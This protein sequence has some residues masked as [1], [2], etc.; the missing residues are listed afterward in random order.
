M[1]TKNNIGV[2]DLDNSYFLYEDVDKVLNDIG[3]LYDVNFTMNSI[4]FTSKTID[5][6]HWVSDESV[7]TF[8]KLVPKIKSL[9]KDM[10]S[11]IEGIYKAKYGDFRKLEIEKDY[12]NLRELRLFNNKLKH[13][14]DREAEIKLTKL[15]I[16]QPNENIIDCFIQFRYI[17]TGEF[18]AL[19]FTDLINVFLRVLESEKIITIENK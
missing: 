8:N 17:K 2:Y 15:A 9:A 16:I 4:E 12:A 19:R 11:I 5:K 7:S 10:Y 1:T 3:E 14:N 13:H 18:N 6:N